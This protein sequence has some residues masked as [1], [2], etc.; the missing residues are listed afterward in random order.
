MDYMDLQNSQEREFEKLVSKAEEKVEKTIQKYG[1]DSEKGNE[2]IK[3]CNL[4]KLGW[5]QKKND[6]GK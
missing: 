3:I 4:R 5:E 6:V 1:K 2:S